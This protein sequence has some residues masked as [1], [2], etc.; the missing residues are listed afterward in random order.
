MS[1]AREVL[2]AREA[3][4][5]PKVPPKQHNFY[6]STPPMG[7]SF[8]PAV[9]SRTNTKI[10]AEEEDDDEI[11]CNINCGRERLR[12]MTRWIAYVMMLGLIIFV[13]VVN[14]KT[15]SA[16]FSVPHIFTSGSTSSRS[17]GSSSG[18]IVTSSAF[19]AN[20]TLPDK[21]TC[22]FGTETGV[23]PPLAWSN[24]PEGTTDFM[25]TMKKESGYSWTVYDLL[26]LDHVDEAVSNAASSGSTVGEIAGTEAWDIDVPPYISTAGYVSM[27]KVPGGSIQHIL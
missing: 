20:G 8:K 18:F 24:P 19:E 26:L 25:I 2:A 13:L 10:I 15:L 27:Y 9:K 6:G 7:R 23:S 21:Y 5:K 3:L 22:K 17:R 12:H 4:E 14:R 1:F 11:T 16:K